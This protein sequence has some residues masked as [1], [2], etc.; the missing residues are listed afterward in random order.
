MMDLGL[1]RLLTVAGS[2]GL[3]IFGMKLMSESLQQV[4]GRR[5]QRVVGRMTADRARGALTGF[6]ATLVVQYS[7]V[8]SV[9]VVSFVN[10]GLISLRKA[11]PVLIGANLGT[12]VKLLLFAAIGFSAIDLHL[13]AGPLLAAALPLLLL[14]HQTAR[15]TSHL[16]V[17]IALLFLALSLLKGNLDTDVGALEFLGRLQATALPGRLAFVAMGVVLAVFIQSSSVAMVLTLALCTSGTLDFAAGAALALGENIGTTFT[18]NF[19]ALGGNA[20]AKRAARAHLFIKLFGATWAFILFR[21]VLL[22]VAWLTMQLHG[23]DPFTDAAVLKWSLAYFHFGFNLINGLV[24]L[25]LIPWLERAASRLVPVRGRNQEGFRLNYM[26]DP[27]AAISPSISLM[28]TRKEIAKLAGLCRRMLSMVRTLLMANDNEARG[29]LLGRIT[30][31][32]TIIGRVERE[33]AHFL[34]RTAMVA[35]D[36]VTV[37]RILGFQ[38]AAKELELAG[39]AAIRMAQILERKAGQR[40]W[41]SPAQRQSLLDGLTAAEQGLKAL[42]DRMD[43]RTG[44]TRG[45]LTQGVNDQ[46]GPAVENEQDARASMMFHELMEACRDL[47][48][49]VENADRAASGA[50]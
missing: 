27:L 2:V 20:W 44:N 38:R 23:A 30:K 47:S 14:R 35:R 40:L 19:A 15:A 18:A 17:G 5:M 41:F 22:G 1:L 4:A 29:K 12:T 45:P 43:A 32:G 28:E 11:I 39:D 3:L 21:P 42:Q 10:S 48:A 50:A 13:I 37:G 25:N 34:A 6:M 49:H 31:Y 8:V 9:L 46:M 7:S 26:A 24:L 36:D 33:V 16:L